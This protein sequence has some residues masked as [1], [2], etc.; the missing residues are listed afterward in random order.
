MPMIF[1]G[2]EV[3]KSLDPTIDLNKRETW[4][5]TTRSSTIT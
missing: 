4:L 3:D 1:L 2:P 5:L